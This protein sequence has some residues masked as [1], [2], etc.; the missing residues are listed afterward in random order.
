[1][2]TNVLTIYVIYKNPRDYPGK[3]VVRA[4]DANDDGS[5]SIHLDCAVCESLEHARQC[6]PPGL[7]MLMRAPEDDPA[8]YETWL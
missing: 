1:M 5:I 3:W 4:Q 6:V 8:I 2:I 7:V